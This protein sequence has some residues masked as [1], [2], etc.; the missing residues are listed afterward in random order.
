M[1]SSLHISMCINMLELILLNLVLLILISG[2]SKKPIH[3]QISTSF[4][5]SH[6]VVKVIAKEKKEKSHLLHGRLIHSTESSWEC[7]QNIQ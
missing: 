2:V 3:Q 6:P 7:L 4:V 5:I 1:S